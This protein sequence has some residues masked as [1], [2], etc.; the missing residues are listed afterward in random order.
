MLCGVVGGGE[1]VNDEKLIMLLKKFV[2]YS[3][4]Q[5]F[6]CSVLS[7]AVSK[8]D[9]LMS[10][11][12]RAWV[13]CQKSASLKY[14]W[15]FSVSRFTAARPALPRAIAPGLAEADSRLPNMRESRKKQG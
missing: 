9:E 8:F 6:S 7:Y 5:L 10:K 13:Y 12:S 11:A 15:S 2:S 3:V 1:K 14:E 4:V